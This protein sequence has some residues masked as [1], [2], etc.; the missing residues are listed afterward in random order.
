MLAEE[1]LLQIIEFAAKRGDVVLDLSKKGLRRIPPEI[2]KL[3]NLTRLSLNG[4]RLT[5]IPPEIGQLKNLRLLFLGNNQLSMLPP[6]IGELTNLH[7]LALV[8]NQLSTLPPEIGELTNLNVLALVKNQ[9]TALPPEIGQLKNLEILVVHANPLVFPPPEIV[10]QGTLAIVAHLREHLQSS[11]VQWVSKLL[12]LGEGG[13]GKTSLLRA[14]AGRSFDPL[15]PST[16][17]LEMSTLGLEHPTKEGVTMQLKAWDF[18]GQEIYHTTHQFFLT[19]RSLF[20]LVWNTRHGYRQ[21]KLYYWLDTIQAKAPESPVLIVAT[22]LDERKADLPV[23][24]LRQKYPQIVGQYN[25]SNRT[26]AGIEALR[27]R[28]TDTAAKLPLMGETWPA[29]WLD[30]AEAIRAIGENYITAH[31]LWDTMRSHKVSGEN[32]W[33]LA[34][35]LHE[36]GDILFYQDIE[37]LEDMVILK[38]LWVTK[39]ISQVLESKEVIKHAGILTRDHRDEL[40]HDIE[41]AMRDH[42]LRLMEC[43]DIS[44][45][46]LEDRDVS[47]VVERLPLDPPDFGKKWA[48]IQKDG[49]YSEISMKFMLNTMQ[50]GIPT[51]FIARSH[52]FS[53]GNHWRG[54]ALFADNP[55]ESHLALVEAF[56]HE[57][58]LQLT[59]RGPHPQN[60][61][62]LLR[63]G[64]ELTLKRFPGLKVERLVPCPGH[65]GK[66]CSHEFKYDQLLHRL[67]EDSSRFHLEC[68]EADMDIDIRSLLFGLVP[69][70]FGDVRIRIEKS[71]IEKGK[72]IFELI[73][74]LQ[75]E[76][77]KRYQEQQKNRESHCPNVFAV[78]QLRGKGGSSYL[79][80]LYCQAPGCWHPVEKG[81]HYGID[82]LSQWAPRLAPHLK[83]M[84]S[85]LKYAS[86]SVG[87][88]TKMA[89]SQYKKLIKYDVLFMEE[90]L[91]MLHGVLTSG[92]S[93]SSY[94]L[95]EALDQNRRDVS[96]MQPLRQLLDRKDPKQD[97]GGLRKVLT[98][99]G[100][101]LWL[102]EYHARVYAQ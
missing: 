43:F 16:H 4:N 37:E 25:I 40:W 11:R 12:V 46:T 60:F 91:K 48:S 34:R 24:D 1:K 3:T 58:C 27:Q 39:Y 19:N 69:S 73:E 50:A 61:F 53:T 8:N 71:I 56:P 41:P 55:Q 18:G 83:K 14:L 59:V 49:P 66:P 54:G 6:E 98:P 35:W 90:L 13:V 79:I 7:V 101:Y 72:P 85:P 22:H 75:R 31:V 21:G 80:Q 99:E 84:L 77:L 17:G 96:S 100:H 44:H 74:L 5:S 33:V 95:G 26:G 42:F 28:I 45:R 86:L 93:D 47:L 30:A 64:L 88:W 57:R 10:R 38:P 32:A 87:P 92:M 36:L 65:E 62:A 70:T 81:G 78:R 2:G 76:F 102:C 29:A 9:L 20:L 68:P 51:W 67:E 63:D 89:P 23:K 94:G 52:R 15:L 97:W 82:S